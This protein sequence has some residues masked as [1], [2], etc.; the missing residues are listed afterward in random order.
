MIRQHTILP[1]ILTTIILTITGQHVLADDSHNV[2]A[3]WFSSKTS[4]QINRSTMALAGGHLRRGVYYA[5]VALKDGLS[6]ADQLIANHNLCLAYLG[7]GQDQQ[8][9]DFCTRV[10][11]IAHAGFY[12]NTIRGGNY[13]VS[14]GVNG[15]EVLPALSAVVIDNIYKHSGSHEFALSRK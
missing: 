8:A 13:I 7:L 2:S 3:I 1:V 9:A 10:I 5:R 14:K 6:E 15:D 12:V 4:P 11:D